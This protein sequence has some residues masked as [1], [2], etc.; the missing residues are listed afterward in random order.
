MVLDASNVT[1][2]D[3]YIGGIVTERSRLLYSMALTEKEK[4]IGLRT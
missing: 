4:L 1:V 2:Q 3:G